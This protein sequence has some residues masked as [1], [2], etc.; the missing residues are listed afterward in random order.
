MKYFKWEKEAFLEKC[1]AV[2]EARGAKGQQIVCLE[3]G[4]SVSALA[5]EQW[6]I[7]VSTA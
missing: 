4:D 1:K 7:L 3:P 5:Y 2:Y 6:K